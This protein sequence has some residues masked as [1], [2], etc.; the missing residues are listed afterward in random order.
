LQK[1][2]AKITLER[3]FYTDHSFEK[4]TKTKVKQ[5]KVQKQKIHYQQEI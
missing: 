3:V 4:L 1:Q 5:E 2:L